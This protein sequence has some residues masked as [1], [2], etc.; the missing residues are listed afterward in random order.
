M[1][2][3]SLLLLTLGR[4]PAAN[5]TKR[6]LLLKGSETPRVSCTASHDACTPQ[7]ALSS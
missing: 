6:Y 7:C 5:A 4:L 2:G 1:V 3:I